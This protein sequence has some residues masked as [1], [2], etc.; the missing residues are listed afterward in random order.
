MLTLGQASVILANGRKTG[1]YTQTWDILLSRLAEEID[2]QAKKLGYEEIFLI[3][4]AEENTVILYT[5]PKDGK[6]FDLFVKGQ[7]SEL[8]IFSSLTTDENAAILSEMARLLSQPFDLE[9]AFE[10]WGFEQNTF[11]WIAE[12]A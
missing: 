9:S 3:D 2:S 10:S 1:L 5:L 6:C 4:S 7:N 11:A 8:E 12:C